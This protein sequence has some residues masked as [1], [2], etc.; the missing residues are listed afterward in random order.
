MKN[1]FQLLQDEGGKSSW[2]ILKES[3]VVAAEETIPRKERKSNLTTIVILSRGRC[4]LSRCITR[5]LMGMAVTDLLVL[6]TAVILNRLSII[7]FP[8][9]FLSTTPVCSLKIAVI[10]AARDSSVWLTVAFTIDRFVA[11]CCQNW[12]TKYCTE[13]MA[14]VLIAAVCAV[15][16][17]KNIPWYFVY[18]PL[19]IIDGAKWFC[20]IKLSFYSELFWAAFDWID[21]ILNPCAPFLLMLSL[22]A[23][24]VRN[25]LVA[26]RA[27]RRL[28]VQNT[29]DRQ[30]DPEMES[31]RKS[32]VLLF[33]ISGS[34]L[35]LWTMYVINFLYVRFTDNN[36]ST[37]SNF[38]DPWFILQEAGNMSQLLSC[39]TNTCIYAGT[40]TKFREEF[41]N[42]LK[43]PLN[44]IRN[45]GRSG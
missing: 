27:R 1:H 14:R 9:F 8:I 19:Y 39:C 2:D 43:Y 17:V 4:G 25:I 18:E 7:Y 36:Y 16:C 26:N 42:G 34:F 30:N 41:I 28:R 12:K 21:R 15:S 38:N 40:Q 24:T 5:Y 23:L 32:I 33:T 29:G 37:G 35:V 20:N 44:L 11:I 45:F 10:Y 6:I 13:R 3:M 22:N 31:R